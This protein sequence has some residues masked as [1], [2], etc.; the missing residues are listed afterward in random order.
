M[1]ILH[2]YLSR[3]DYI[4]SV[5][6]AADKRLTEREIRYLVENALDAIF[7]GDDES[8]DENKLLVGEPRKIDL[9]DIIRLN[10]EICSISDFP[11]AQN[12]KGRTKDFEIHILEISLRNFRN[13]DGLIIRPWP[14]TYYSIQTVSP[15]EEIDG[16][17]L[18]VRRKMKWISELNI[19]SNGIHLQEVQWPTRYL[20]ERGR[21]FDLRFEHDPEV[22][23]HQTRKVKKFFNRKVYPK[24]NNEKE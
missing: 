6:K 20:P 19:F 4:Y 1:N 5:A 21:I 17:Y 15:N 12:R 10:F 11:K 18:R 3:I 9:G 14:K 24:K 13:R 7:R 22:S 16:V 2:A 23:E 8:I